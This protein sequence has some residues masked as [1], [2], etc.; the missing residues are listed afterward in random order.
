VKNF[1]IQ[2]MAYQVSSLKGLKSVPRS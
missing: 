2:F 1:C